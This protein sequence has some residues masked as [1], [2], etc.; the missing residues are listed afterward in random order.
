ML[1]VGDAA[2]QQKCLGKMSEVA[3]AGAPCSS[4]AIK[5]RPSKI[6]ARAASCS[7][8][9]ALDFDGTQT[10]ALEFYAASAGQFN[11][12]LQHR[13]D[14][15]GSGDIRVTQI[16]MRNARGERITTTAAGQDVDI[17]LHFENVTGRAW[18]DLKV[19]LQAKNQFDI[20]IFRHG[21]LYTGESFGPALPER[22]RLVCRLPKLPLPAGS[23]RLGYMLRTQAHGSQLI[24]AIEGAVDLHVEGGDF[25][26]SGQV[27]AAHDGVCLVEGQWRLVANA[28]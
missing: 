27:P 20:P 1:A 12:E 16:E 28:A 13:S 22:G 11:G 21:N 25:F 15:Q 10:D 24:D 5:P 4:S 26:A 3:R 18:P 23:Y 2:F 17:A 19:Y 8:T 6:S 14:R 7:K 9:A